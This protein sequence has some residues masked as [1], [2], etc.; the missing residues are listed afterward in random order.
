L[1]PDLHEI[2]SVV[3]RAAPDAERGTPY[4]TGDAADRA[5]SALTEA[6]VGD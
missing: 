5:L 6:S 1:L 2:S 3:L 4:G